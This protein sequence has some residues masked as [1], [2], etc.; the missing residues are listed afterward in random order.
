MGKNV[1]IAVDHYV[2]DATIKPDRSELFRVNDDGSWTFSD[3]N[4]GL[5]S[6]FR[7]RISK[8]TDPKTILQLVKAYSTTETIP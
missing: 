7:T 5:G 6:P 1:F 3:Q 4:I 2:H 8:E